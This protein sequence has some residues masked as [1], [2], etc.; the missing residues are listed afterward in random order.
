LQNITRPVVTG[1]APARTDAV[2]VTGSPAAI[3]EEESA[4]VVL[5]ASCAAPARAAVHSAAMATVTEIR[6]INR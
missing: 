4:M 6:M 5:V 1:V 3:E 2:S